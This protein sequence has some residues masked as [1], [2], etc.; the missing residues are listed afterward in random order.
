MN[1]VK[2]WL[3]HV[4]TTYPRRVYLLII[5]L[6]LIAASQIPKLTIDTDPENMLPASHPVRV[7][8]AMTKAR[9]ALYDSIVIGAI[10]ESE[11]GVF[12]PVS[13]A[14]MDAI[15]RQI[16]TLD[17][18]VAADLM[19]LSTVDNI[20][21]QGAGTIHFDYMMRS[22][23]TDQAGSDQIRRALQR[24]PLLNNTLVSAD[25]KA[26]AIYV[27]LKDKS[28]S[29]EVAQQIRAII[30]D[31]QPQDDYH[32]TG[33]PVA[34]NQF[35]H[36]MFV[37][38]AVAAP[39]AGLMIF[40]LMWY[41]FRSI[42]LVIAP[43]LV[44]MATVIIT[45]G[46]LIGLG[47]TVHIMSSMIAI[48]LMPIAV[49][50]S[51]HI[52]SEFADNY[53]PGDKVKTVI[54]KVVN[55]LFT[56]M[57]F[58]S[59]T[60]AVGFVSLMLT[61]IPPVQVFGAFVGGGI[62]LALLLTLLILPAYLVRM[63]PSALSAMQSR[64]KRRPSQL[65]GALGWLSTQTV[66]RSK[67]IAIVSALLLGLSWWG[68]SQIRVNDN[69]I[70]WFKSDHPLRI[71]DSA[72]NHH[73][74]GTYD[75]YLVLTSIPSSAPHELTQATIKQLKA[76]L[77]ATVMLA[78]QGDNEAL[79]RLL[80]TL[81]DA[82][83]DSGSDALLPLIAQWETFAERQ[84]R[85][86]SPALLSWMEALQQHLDRTGLVGKSNS[87]VDVTKTVNR[88]LHSGTDDDLALPTSAQGV[89]Q[90]LLQ[91]QSSHRPQ[92]LWHFVTSD[93]RH[94]LI[95]LQLTS[96]DNQHMSQVMDEVS[97]YLTQHPLPA[98]I[99]IDWA[100]KAYINV[101][102]QQAMVSGMGESLISAFVVVLVMMVLLFRSPLYGVLAMLPLTLTIS[103]IYGLIGW[104]G[105][106]YDMPIAVLS[107]LTLGLSVDFAIHFLERFREQLKQLGDVRLALSAMFEEPAR[108]ISRNAI[109]IALGFT[110]LL[111]SPL[112][113]YVTV[114]VLLASIMAISAVTTLLLLPASL[115]LLRSV[116]HP[117]GINAPEALQGES[118]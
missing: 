102:W 41:F 38:M 18:V 33:L 2:A 88:D 79:D 1:Q 93:Y 67:G 72:L 29:F 77:S 70:R 43:M 58:T 92:D 48:F 19:A 62:L 109:V 45:M 113:P 94:G 100:G 76:P 31:Q 6:T 69:P 28:L 34:E 75:G 35:G 17:G 44:A 115:W 99:D 84:R 8:D 97:A 78:A 85:F 57:L 106:D 81:E 90:A 63:S 55:D 30:A 14:Q 39:L 82:S 37:Q 114:G 20:S 54:T 104:L 42:P 27:P 50:D 9:F 23:P 3:S 110:P 47:Y 53:Q 101:A 40:L 105:K 52:M 73:F 59:I 51:I 46:T 112:V 11:N 49:V 61:P 7:F 98:G 87:L 13:L 68:I 86:L 64:L 10:N 108:A 74:A 24:L 71:A 12:N 15:T 26:A 25:G 95:W 118:K 91:Y 22:A 103:L 65:A 107:A 4:A 96:G 117:S 80:M 32:L 16:L 36:E 83:F 60:S 116:I 66:H 89:A 111:L 21:Q 5:A 56:P